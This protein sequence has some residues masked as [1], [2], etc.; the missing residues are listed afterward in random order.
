MLNFLLRAELFAAG[1]YPGV[2]YI[3]EESSR[4]EDD[5]LITLR[6]AYPLVKKLE[7]DDWPVSVLLIWRQGGRLRQS[8]MRS[9]LHSLWLLRCHGWCLA[10]R[11]PS[12]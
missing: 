2:D 5:D 1:L 11:S 4:D 7:R 3:I 9:L 10:S 12:S 6:P 8:T